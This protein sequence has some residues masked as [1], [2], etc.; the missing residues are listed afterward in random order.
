MSKYQTHNIFLVLLIVFALGACTSEEPESDQQKP[1]PDYY[2]LE[3]SR[4]DSLIKSDENIK[5]YSAVKAL[6]RAL[7]SEEELRPEFLRSENYEVARKYVFMMIAG[8]EPDVMETMMD[9]PAILNLYKIITETPEEFY[10]LKENNY[11]TI[12][13]STC[14]IVDQDLALDE[15][16]AAYESLILAATL[17]YSNLSPGLAMYEFDNTKLQLIA[18]NEI[19]ALAQLYY[20][21]ECIR[22]NMPYH[23]V[24]HAT[25]ALKTIQNA[26]KLSGSFTRSFMMVSDDD[27]NQTKA[28]FEALCML[29]QGLAFD[30]MTDVDDRKKAAD[31]FKGFLEISANQAVGSEWQILSEGIS[32]LISNGNNEAIEELQLLMQSKNLTGQEKF[33]IGRLLGL[34]EGDNVTDDVRNLV[35]AGV[36]AEKLYS[37]LMAS[38]FY[39]NL[40]DS[41][42]GESFTMIMHNLDDY[43]ETFNTLKSISGGL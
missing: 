35:I 24:E 37:F 25:G 23:A 38:D 10:E 42:A 21:L 4:I 20:S 40:T 7:G 12:L 1:K 22:Y 11:P 18:D 6:V 14:N 34:A 39:N 32:K 28:N 9:I 8:E 26:D 29:V 2:A 19:R 13:E 30:Q 17:R 16:N 5:H 31:A 33:Q 36:V 27:P 41:E 43:V 3:E 15:W